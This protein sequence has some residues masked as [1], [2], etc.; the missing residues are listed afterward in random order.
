[1]REQAAR[2][3]QMSEVLLVAADQSRRLVGRQ[4][5]PLA[6]VEERVVER[7]EMLELGEQRR[8]QRTSRNGEVGAN[9]ARHL[10]RHPLV[11]HRGPAAD[12]GCRTDRDLVGFGE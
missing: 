6:L 3:V 11:A 7:S 8:R 2:K 1:L 10:L 9:R 5:Q 12:Y 4:P